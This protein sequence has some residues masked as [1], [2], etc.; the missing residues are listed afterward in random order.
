MQC[1]AYKARAKVQYAVLHC[2]HDI[3]GVCAVVHFHVTLKGAMSPQQCSGYAIANEQEHISHPNA[4]K[5]AKKKRRTKRKGSTDKTADVE[6]TE[7]NYVLCQW[8]VDSKFDVSLSFRLWYVTK[9][10]TSTLQPD[11]M[12]RIL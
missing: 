4:E 9:L 1:A 10:G 5:K 2:E 3:R 6:P 11:F 7:G 8:I 12:Y